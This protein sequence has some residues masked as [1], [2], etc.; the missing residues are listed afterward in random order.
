[1]HRCAWLSTR[2]Q[3]LGGAGLYHPRKGSPCPPGAEGRYRS[4]SY[5]GRRSV[6][7]QTVRKWSPRRAQ[8]VLAGSNAR[9]H[10]GRLRGTRASSRGYSRIGSPTAI[11]Y[12]SSCRVSRSSRAGWANVRTGM[13][14]SLAAI[15]PNSSRV[16]RNGSSTQLLQP[17]VQRTNRRD[18]RQR[19]PHPSVGFPQVMKLACSSVA[20][21]EAISRCPENT[22]TN[23]T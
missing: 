1:M 5:A 12:R 21:R 18:Q 6:R 10:H 14:P 22:G 19:R 15:P 7:C 8:F 2:I 23:Q 16:T 3:E 20:F 17:G 11:P 9:T 4:Q 13:G